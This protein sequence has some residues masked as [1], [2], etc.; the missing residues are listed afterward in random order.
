MV[1]EKEARL[2]NEKESSNNFIYLAWGCLLMLGA[3]M[4]FEP[5]AQISID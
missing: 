3:G 5:N 4:S 2:Q 1:K